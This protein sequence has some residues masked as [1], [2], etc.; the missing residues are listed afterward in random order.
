[1]IAKG[2]LPPERIR[3]TGS[4][5]IERPAREGRPGEVGRCFEA[6]RRE[7]DLRSGPRT[8]GHVLGPAP[9][10][11]PAKHSNWR[12]GDFLLH[13][14]CVRRYIT[15]GYDRDRPASVRE[16]STHSHPLFRAS[17]N[18]PST[19]LPHSAVCF[20]CKGAAG[21]V[22]T[23]PPIRWGR[24]IGSAALSPSWERCSE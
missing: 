21:P 19:A 12:I 23:D 5:G 2:A 7:R 6:I 11:Q 16:P 14:W 17:A 15:S 18:Y 1:M 24:T 22:L 3:A 10:S 8:G 20:L 4:A 9:G 13:A